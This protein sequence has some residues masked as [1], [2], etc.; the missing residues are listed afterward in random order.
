MSTATT[1]RYD[2]ALAR[3]VRY[4]PGVIAA[5]ESLVEE[6][7]DFA[8]GHALAAYLCLTSTDVPDL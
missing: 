4:H 3:L 1:D 7:P 5:T 8:M 2:L 6:H